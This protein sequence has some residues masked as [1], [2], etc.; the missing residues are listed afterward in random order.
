M[1][2]HINP[3][4]QF[5]KEFVRIIFIVWE[6]FISLFLLDILVFVF[7]LLLGFYKLLKFGK[8]SIIL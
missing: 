5:K 8:R 4:L 3:L 1:D 6:L 7:Y 2:R